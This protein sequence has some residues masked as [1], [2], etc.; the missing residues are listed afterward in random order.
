MRIYLRNVKKH[1]YALG[2]LKSMR[3]YLRNDV[4]M[5]VVLKIA[6]MKREIMYYYYF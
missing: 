3:I 5:S 2:T 1:A 4:E 6:T